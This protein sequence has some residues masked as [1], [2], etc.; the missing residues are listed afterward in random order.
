MLIRWSMLQLC[1]TLIVMYILQ[2]MGLIL[3]MRWVVLIVLRALIWGEEVCVSSEC[4]IALD[5]GRKLCAM[6]IFPTMKKCK[7]KKTTCPICL[8]A[9]TDTILSP[10]GHGFHQDCVIQWL[11]QSDQC[12]V[13]RCVQKRRR[14][15]WVE[16]K[17]TD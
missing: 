6:W 5:E 13:C 15:Q 7:R 3:L 2:A 11:R 14:T 17:S 8:C 16:T 10:C 1:Q 12:P 4:P 9:E